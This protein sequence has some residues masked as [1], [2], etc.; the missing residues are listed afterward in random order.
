MKISKE[1]VIE[2]ALKLKN[3]L[4]VDEIIGID[5]LI[6]FAEKFSNNQKFKFKSFIIKSGFN[7]NPNEGLKKILIKQARDL[8]DEIV[9][10]YSENSIQEKVEILSKKQ[11]LFKIEPSRKLLAD[12]IGLTKCYPSQNFKLDNVNLELR[13]GEITGVVGVNAQGK[14]TLLKLIAGENK[15]D[16]G[17]IK[18]SLYNNSK[19]NNDWAKIKES[20]AYLPQELPTRIFGTVEESIMLSA[21]VHGISS[22][23][24][25]YKTEYIIH[26]LGLGEMKD[27]YYK[28]LSG[29]FK[30][31][32]LLAHILV[33]EPKIIVLDEPLANLDILVKTTLLNDLRHLANSNSNPM[34][35]IISSHDVEEVESVA[36]NMIIL[37]K[38]AVVYN[39]KTTNIGRNL[40]GNKYEIKSSLPFDTIRKKFAALNLINLQMV[41][42]STII[43]ALPEIQSKDL[44]K[45]CI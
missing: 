2:E 38:G 37:E 33:W 1:Q 23:E 34:S 22:K 28:N 30:L 26:R 20:L 6:G 12:C 13:E 3:E 32:L 7:N 44:L 39:G 29:G 24:S 15:T 10:S 40:N 11:K 8:I 21:A 16:S 41:G 19:K 17:E 5:F 45:Y 9:S 31:R 18:F 14:S 36:N 4:L 42:S 25:E 27:S 43:S 35:I